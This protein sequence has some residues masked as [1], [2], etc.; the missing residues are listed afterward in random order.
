MSIEAIKEALKA[1]P[2][3]GRWIHLPGERTVY[4]RLEDGCRGVPSG[5]G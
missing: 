2:T 1:G 5:D 4:T 3:E